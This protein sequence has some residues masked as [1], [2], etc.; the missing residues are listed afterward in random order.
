MRVKFLGL[1][2]AAVLPML[3]G[4]FPLH[5]DQ[6]AEAANLASLRAAF[7][8]PP[9]DS[10]IM[11]RWWWF[12]P[13]VT[14]SEL[15]REMQLMKAGGI[16][17]FEVQTTYP[18]ALDDPGHNFKNFDFLS[19]AHLDALRYV[20]SEARQLGLRMDL[21][22]GSGWPYGGP[23]VPV[24][25]AA[26][27][28]RLAAVAVDPGALDLPLPYI[29]TGEKLL[30]VF[31]AKGDPARFE[32]GSAQELTDIK[33]GRVH[34]PGGLQDPHVVLFF[35]AGRTGQTVKRAA[36]GAEGFVLDHYDRAALDHYL[37]TTGS[38]FMQA[39]PVNPPRAIFCDSLEV[40]ESDWTGD[41]LDEFQKRRSYD[42]RPYLP[43]LVADIGPKTG[44][45]RHDWGKTLTELFTENF[46]APLEE[47]ARAHHTLLRAQLY[48][49]P[50]AVLSNY[51]L[52]D[53]PEGEGAHWKEFAPT[54]WASSAG[55]LYGRPVTSSETWTWLHSPA[56]RATPLDIK[57]E[58]DVHFLEG[59]NQFVGHGW[60][61][62]P[63]A[64]GEPGWRFY[65]AAVLNAHN[66][67]WLVMPDLSLYLQRMSFLLRQGR[68]VNDVA[69]YVPTDDA[70][71]H[72]SPGEASVSETVARLL[73]PRLIGNILDAGYGFDFI[74]DD[75]ITRLAKTNARA[76]EVNGNRY[77]IVILPNVERI[78]VMTLQKLAAFARDGVAVVAT[79]RAPSLAPG[80][81]NAESES[82]QIAALSRQL[83]QGTSAA[84]HLVKDD[85][86]DL[87]TTLRGLRQ[88]DVRLSPPAPDVGFVHRTTGWAEIYFF[89]NTGNQSIATMATFRVQG[90]EADWWDPFTGKAVAAGVMTRSN[91]GTTLA[92]NLE[93]YGSRVLVFARQ[94]VPRVPLHPGGEGGSQGLPMPLDL[95]SGWRVSFLRTNLNSAANLASLDPSR[96]AQDAWSSTRMDE[97]RSW[98]DD[99]ATRFFSGLA[100]YEKTFSV[101]WAAAGPSS[102]IWLD[103]GEGTAIPPAPTR[104]E[105]MQTW[106]D[107]P[108][109][110]A[111]VVYVNGQRAGSVWH[112][113]YTVNVTGLLRPG[114]NQL[115][116]VVAN[117]AINEMAGVALPDYRLL[118]SRY[119]ERF[120]PQDM[121]HL[122]PL[123]SG[124]LGSIRLVA[125][126]AER[127]AGAGE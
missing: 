40:Y 107:S 78:P 25:E 116:V 99:N 26:G 32:A 46:V 20:S 112:P 106:F 79:R 104:S 63:E 81:M 17:G 93:P 71:A 49:I 108:V 44:A 115:Q 57:A 65:A 48:G 15:L 37:A 59:I 21:T 51:R 31:L 64:A 126:P 6:A 10:K 23:G 114:E 68:P 98:S 120:T 36:L 28:L 11:V 77:S 84:G 18:L 72:F 102:E 110:D 33:D 94:F 67:W 97:L 62:S 19:D 53:L 56:F 24:T 80:L 39:F 95:S 90:R 103:F 109:R 60:P 105:G 13:A 52:I 5:Q 118:D 122:Q 111:A 73:G 38:R 47:W 76:L 70:W 54:R 16:G 4:V 91:E 87:G 22:L 75:A 123:P 3:A 66:P 7:L 86:S 42:L 96:L 117:T 89:A 45:I 74:D 30:A 29:G 2:A 100:L 61:Y 127:E 9:E 83:F 55:H 58:A 27:R 113:P 8:H 92:L 41:F 121:E 14:H 119:G 85:D 69:L 124:L 35:V 34:L 43:A 82:R 1:A 101:P 88:P 12:W 125:R 50:P